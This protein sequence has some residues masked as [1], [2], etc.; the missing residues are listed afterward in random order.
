M[1]GKKTKS[2]TREITPDRIYNSVAVQKV[3][4]RVMHDG[5]KQVAED[6][7]MVACKKLPTS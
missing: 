7:F 3:I 5:K 6:L 2:L 4:N 1:P